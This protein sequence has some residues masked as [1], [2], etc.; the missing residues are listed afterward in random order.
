VAYGL[1][2][3]AVG[4][5][6]YCVIKLGGYSL[7]A[8]TISRAYARR[9]RNAWL[10]GAT[11]TAIGMAAGALYY[12]LLRSLPAAFSPAGPVA[13]LGGLVPIRVVEWWL[14]LWWFYDRRLAQK[15]KGWLI[16]ALGIVWSYVLDV[17]ALAGVLATGGFSVC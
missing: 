7:A 16:V 2:H 3:P 17:P 15:K 14:L 1:L 9:D 5:A 6:T 12:L 4:Y 11:R 13:L 8:H 10:V